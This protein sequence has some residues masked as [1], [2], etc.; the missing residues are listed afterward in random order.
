MA[1]IDWQLIVALLAVAGA[2]WF[3]VRRG[4]ALLQRGKK[5]GRG[6][7][8]SCGSCAAGPS[9]ASGAPAQFVPLDSLMLKNDRQP[10]EQP[11]PGERP[12]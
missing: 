4:M 9:A 6:D 2:A 8:G 7:C 3:L 11:I 5:A 10:H 1:N 12:A